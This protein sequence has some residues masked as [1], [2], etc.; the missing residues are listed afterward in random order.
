MD[1]FSSSAL[2]TNCNAS[3]TLVTVLYVSCTLSVAS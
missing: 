1:V 3:N 2:Q